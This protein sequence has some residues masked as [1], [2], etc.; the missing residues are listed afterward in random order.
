[1]DRVILNWSNV[2]YSWSIAGSSYI[3][4]VLYRPQMSFVIA[5]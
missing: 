5:G 1:M 3:C 2:K 4:V